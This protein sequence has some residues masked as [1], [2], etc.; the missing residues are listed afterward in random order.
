MILYNTTF[1]IERELQQPFVAYLREVLVPSIVKDGELINPSLHRVQSDEEEIIS[2][3]LQFC[4]EDQETLLDYMLRAGAA[5][6]EGVTKQFPS[7]VHGFTTI[8][9]QISL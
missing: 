7:K 2:L 9:E 6:F 1:A 4:V 3:A 8:M 5:H